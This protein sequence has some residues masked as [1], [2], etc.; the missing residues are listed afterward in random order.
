MATTNQDAR[1]AP[2][3]PANAWL[4]FLV[5]F[6]PKT[7]ITPLVAF[8]G[9]CFLRRAGITCRNSWKYHPGRKQPPFQVVLQP[10]FLSLYPGVP[11]QAIPG[12][13]LAGGPVWLDSFHR[14]FCRSVDCSICPDTCR[15]GG[16][17]LINP[18]FIYSLFQK[19]GIGVSKF[20][21]RLRQILG[22]S[23]KARV[24]PWDKQIAENRLAYFRQSMAKF[25]C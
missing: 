4:L 12:N 9:L 18:F 6:P 17:I 25:C 5:S 22:M 24:M 1:H 15:C 11:T 13:T 7:K 14:L 21:Y 8:Q 20:G 3:K 16:S 23:Y 10:V 2:R 19:L